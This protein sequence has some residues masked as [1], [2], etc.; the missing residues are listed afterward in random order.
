VSARPLKACPQCGGR[1]TSDRV[2][3]AQLGGLPGVLYDV[4]S[5]CGHSRAVTVRPRR[6]S[7]PATPRKKSSITP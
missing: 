6:E 4:C 2:D 3:G 1:H 5:S 7:L